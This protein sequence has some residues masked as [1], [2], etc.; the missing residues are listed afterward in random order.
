MPMIDRVEVAVIEET[1]PR[2]LSFLNEE[3][4]LIWLVPEEFAYQAFPN[5]KIARNLAR[6]GILMEQ[7]PTLDTTH[8]F[9]NMEDPVVGGYT[10]EKVALRRAISLSYKVKDEIAILRK[11]QAIAADAPYSPG[12]AG[13]DP[14]FRTTANEYDISKA[15]ALLDMFG[16]V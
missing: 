4:D 2:W 11:G 10:P 5:N 8:S 15:R 7:L 3:M 12:A 14:H 1:Q 9:F 6:R 16:Y 13:Y